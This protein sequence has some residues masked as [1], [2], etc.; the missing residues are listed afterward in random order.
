MKHDEIKDALEAYV[1]GKLDENLK[2]KIEAHIEECDECRS[3]LENIKVLFEF[4]PDQEPPPLSQDF[5]KRVLKG[6]EK[7][8]FERLKELIQLPVVSWPV[9]SFAA[10]ALILVVTVTIYKGIL[11]TKAPDHEILTRD[12]EITIIEGENNIAIETDVDLEQA[13]ERIE[14]LAQINQSEILQV[15]RLE[16]AVLLTLSIPAE[17][18]EAFIKQLNQL[19]TVKIASGGY[20]DTSGNVVIKLVRND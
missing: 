3:H 18:E 12:A 2:K 8:F 4:L 1:K 15:R 5:K 16:D 7:P 19:G 14:E 10:A 20:K 17:E 13:V 9:A 6:I 11:P